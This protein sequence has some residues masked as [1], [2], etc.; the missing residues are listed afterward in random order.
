MARPIESL[1]LSVLFPQTISHPASATAVS[2]SLAHSD[3]SFEVCTTQTDVT[4]VLLRS[5]KPALVGEAHTA[6]ESKVRGL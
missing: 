2:K 6:F 4:G 1:L 5:S 3:A